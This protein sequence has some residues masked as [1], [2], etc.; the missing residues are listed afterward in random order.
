MT[1]TRENGTLRTPALTFDVVDCLLELGGGRVE[2]VSDR[3]DIAPSTAHRHLRTLIETG[4]A[5]KDGDEY[6]VSLKF[7]TIGGYARSQVD[8]FDLVKATVDKLAEETAERAQF[9]VPEEGE[10]VFIFTSTGKNAV[11]AEAKIGRRGPLHCSAAGKAILSHFDEDA[12]HALID[13]QGLPAI[14]EDTITD[15]DTLLEEIEVIREE[16][17]AFNRQ[18]S[19]DGLHAVA[20]PVLTPQNRIYGALSVSGP[21]HRLDGEVFESKYPDI[22]RGLAH[23][24]VLNMRYE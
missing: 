16:N 14:T 21:S 5:V 12:I 7:L 9:E 11:R 3:M 19:T 8:Y 6:D 18:E 1:D 22:V 23:E 20:S 24:L 15:R 13:E 10:R 2:E 4:Y 17:I